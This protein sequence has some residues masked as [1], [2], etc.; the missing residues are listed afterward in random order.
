RGERGA[1]IPGPGLI[2]PNVHGD[3][4]LVGHVDRRERG[5]PVHARQPSRVAVGQDVDTARGRLRETPDDLQPMEAYR[6][7][8]L[9]VRLADVAGLA[10]GC[11]EALPRSQLGDDAAHALQCP[12]EVY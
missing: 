2:D 8:L 1:L 7:A 9:D 5:T 4:R 10:E 11:F 3:A 12:R 6:S